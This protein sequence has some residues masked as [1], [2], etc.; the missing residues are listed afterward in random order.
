MKIKLNKGFTLIE[1]LVVVAIIGILSYVVIGYVYEANAKGRDARR[2]ENI[3]QIAKAIN[4]FYSENG[5]L[6][7]NQTGWCSY[8]SNPTPGYGDV[9]QEDLEPY[10]NPIQ[11]DPAL[12][13]QVGDYLFK[14]IQNST[15]QYELCANLERGTNGTYDQSACAGGVVYNYCIT[16]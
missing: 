2:K 1:L 3:D 11:L 16:Q 8:I 14:N 10:M 6:P 12:H 15:G 13:G 4:M 5:S 9:F 7:G